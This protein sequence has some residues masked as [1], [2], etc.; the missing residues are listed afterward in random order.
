M[1]TIIPTHRVFAAMEGEQRAM[2]ASAEVAEEHDV[3]TVGTAGEVVEE[4]QE[5]VLL[6]GVI[7]APRRTSPSV[8]ALLPAIASAFAVFAASRRSNFAA[9]A[10]DAYWATMEVPS[11]PS[12]SFAAIASRRRTSSS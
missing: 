7:S 9:V 3:E 1:D 12:N 2:S 11:Q 5:G 8:L 6:A 10:A 4:N